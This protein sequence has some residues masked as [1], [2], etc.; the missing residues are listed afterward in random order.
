M[1]NVILFG[2]FRC[3]CGKLHTYS[4]LSDAS[5]CTCGRKLFRQALDVRIAVPNVSGKVIT[6][7]QT[8]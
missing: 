7:R 8:L 4:C 1:S 2:F 3:E 6:L 5:S